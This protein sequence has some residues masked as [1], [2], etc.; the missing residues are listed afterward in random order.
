M[1]SPPGY[2]GEHFCLRPTFVAP[3]K[4]YVIACKQQGND[5]REKLLWQSHYSP[6]NKMVVCLLRCVKDK[7]YYATDKRIRF[8]LFRFSFCH[9]LLC[10]SKE[11]GICFN[12]Y[13]IL[14]PLLHNVKEYC[15]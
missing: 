5:Q 7:E 15:L 9:T 10:F 13:G 4:E 3:I 12:M 11:Y 14:L 6:I 2:V 1:N 8:D